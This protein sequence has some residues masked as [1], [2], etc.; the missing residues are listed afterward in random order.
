MTCDYMRTMSQTRTINDYYVT[1]HLHRYHIDN[2][3]KIGERI[4]FLLRNQRCPPIFPKHQVSKE[5]FVFGISLKKGI[6]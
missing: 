5:T 1:V 2:L 6:D 4:E 3:S